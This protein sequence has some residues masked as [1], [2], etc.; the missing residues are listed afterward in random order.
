MFAIL[1]E[2]VHTY[3]YEHDKNIKAT[4]DRLKANQSEHRTVSF[5]CCTN[6]NTENQ[7]TSLDMGHAVTVWLI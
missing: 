5:L 7:Q 3:S 6:E 2:S 4:F 1:C